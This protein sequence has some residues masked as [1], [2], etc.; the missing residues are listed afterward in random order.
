MKEAHYLG[1]VTGGGK[2]RP[3]PHK[4]QAVQDYL[5][6][7]SKKD[8]RAFQGLARYYQNFILHFFFLAALLTDLTR[9]CQPE[10]IRWDNPCEEAF[11]KLKAMLQEPPV[12]KVADPNHHFT[13]QTDVSD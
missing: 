9:K 7:M 4:V 13:L 8:I 11:Q 5:T 3:D 1:H 12:L 10:K 6:P 2:I